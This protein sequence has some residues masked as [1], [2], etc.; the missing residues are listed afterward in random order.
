MYKLTNTDTVI[1]VADNAFIPNDPANADWQEYQAWLAVP[2][3][4]QP[5]APNTVYT[6][7]GHTVAVP[8]GVT[9]NLPDQS[10]PVTYTWDG[11]V[12][13]LQCCHGKRQ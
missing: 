8:A 13:L 9:V 3:T 7:T 5:A 12:R 10:L 6:I 4:P 1:R 2:N 11:P